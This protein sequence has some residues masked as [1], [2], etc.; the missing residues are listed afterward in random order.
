MKSEEALST[1]TTRDA[2]K[3][4]K[5]YTHTEREKESSCT[6]LTTRLPV[7][8]CPLNKLL[9]LLLQLDDWIR[10]PHVGSLFIDSG[11]TVASTYALL[12]PLFCIFPP[13]TPTPRPHL[14]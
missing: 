13:P 7:A 8:K 14:R 9:L 12:L 11:S 1:R 4:N 3:M 5:M 10:P 6:E 2:H